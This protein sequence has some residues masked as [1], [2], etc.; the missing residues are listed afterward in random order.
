MK[1]HSKHSHHT[2]AMLLT[3]LLALL[4]PSCSSEDDTSD[5]FPSA[6]TELVEANTNHAGIVTAIVTDR[7]ETFTPQGKEITAGTPDTTYRCVCMYEKKGGNNIEVFVLE[8]ALSMLP[9]SHDDYK[10]HPKAPVDILS[11]W[12]SSR[13]INLLV[14]F[15]TTG[16]GTH[17]FGFC[18]DK[19]ETATD[20]TTTVYVS[21]L[22]QQPKGDEESYSEKIYVSL[23]IYQYANTYDYVVF[24]ITTHD[25]KT[26][27]R[28]ALK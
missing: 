26:A 17:A 25:G 14:R 23:P 18:E 8:A 2:A 6:I 19:T 5:T 27:Y 12:R 20:G 24:T 21:L 9:K 1:P 13:Y 28:Y 10:T 4:L 11:Q 22:H 3:L 7:G 16:A 15:L